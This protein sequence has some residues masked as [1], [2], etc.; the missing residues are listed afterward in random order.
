MANHEGWYLKANVDISSLLQANKQANSLLAT[1]RKVDAGSSSIH[2]ND[3]LARTIKSADIATASYIERLKSEGKIYEAN[4]NKASLFA[5]QIDKLKNHQSSLETQLTKVARASGKNS[6]AYN[7]QKT[8]I[9]QTATAINE[10]NAKLR[11][12]QSEMSKLKPTGFDAWVAKS[13]KVNQAADTM[14]EKIHGAWDHIKGG[15]TIA[16]AGIGAVGA[17]AVSGAKD[18]GELQQ[19]Y[20]EITNLATLG[21]EKQKA[22]LK[23]VAKM[24]SQGRDMSIQYGKS[25][26][27]IAYGYEDLVKRGYTTKQA[28]GAMRTELQASVASGDKFSDVTTVSSQVL[29]SFGMRADHTKE[30]L[31]NTKTVVN[32]LAYSADAT[33]TGFKDIG[34]GMSYVGA[35]AK[36]AHVSLAETASAMGVLSNNGLEADKA[37]T[38]LRATINSISNQVNKIGSKNSIFDKLGIK[39]SEMVNAKGQLKSL[40]SVMSTLYSHI[41]SKSHDSV[42]EQGYFKSIFG[43]TGMNAAIILAKNTGELKELTRRTAEAGSKGNYVAELAR[44]NGQT[45]QMQFARAKQAAADFKI[46]IGAK[47]L[48]VINDLG[49]DLAKFLNSSDGKKFEKNVAD[50]VKNFGQT[51]I[52]IVK[53]AEQHPITMKVI[54]GGF[55]V[56]YAGVKFARVISFLGDLKSSYDKLAETTPKI[57]KL[58]DYTKELSKPTSFKNMSKAGKLTVAA[59]VAF[60]A[61]Q[62]G[63][64]FQQ[65]A[66]A[67]NAE[68]RINNVGKGIGGIIGGAI[69][70]SLGGFAGAQIGMS[71]GEAMGPS[72]AK[73]FAENFSGHVTKY[74]VYGKKGSSSNGKL[75]NQAVKYI[76]DGYYDVS[77]HKRKG[78]KALYAYDANGYYD[79]RGKYHDQR[80]LAERS[81]GMSHSTDTRKFY[82]PNNAWDWVSGGANLLWNTAG[83]LNDRGFWRRSSHDIRTQSKGSWADFS[84]IGNWFN[85]QRIHPFK[86]SD[87]AGKNHDGKGGHDYWPDIKKWFGS[88]KV[89]GFKWSPKG[90]KVNS[91]ISKWFSDFFHPQVHGKAPSI[92]KMKLQGSSFLPKINGKKWSQGIVKSVKSGWS[93]FTGWSKK[94]GKDSSNKLK[95]GWNGMKSWAGKRKTDIHH[96]WNG[97]TRWAKKLGHGSASKLKGGW[98]GFKSWAG[99]RKKDVGHGWSG[100]KSWA[101]KLGQSSS[102][103]LKGGWKGFKSWASQRK[104]D[105]HHGWNGFTGWSRN[106]GKN[107]SKLLKSGW[108]GMKSWASQRFGQVKSGWSGTQKWFS[109]LGSNAVSAFKKAWS[110]IGDWAKGIWD[111]VSGGINTAVKWGK[112]TWN[113]VTGHSGKGK[114]VKSHATGGAIT[115]SHHALVGEGGPELAYKP[116]ANHARIL[117]A[118]GPELT[119]V[120]AGEH[121]L[122]A[123]DTAKVMSGG[124]GKGY[125]LKGYAAGTTGLKRTTKKVGNDYK[126]M[127]SKSSKELSSFSRKSQRT[128]RGITRKTKKQTATTRK[129]T[130]SDFRSLTRQANKQT[131]K[132]RKNSISDFTSMRK[133]VHSQM[134]KL[135]DGVIDL[136]ESTAKGFGKAM[137]KLHDYARS[138]MSDTIDQINK[139]IRGIDKVLSQFG[140]NASVIK[141]VKFAT[142]T[143][144][145]GRLTKNTLAMLNDAEIG[146]RQEAIVT[147]KNEILMPQGRNTVMPLKRGWGV[148]NGTQTQQ[149]GLT[150]FAKGSG[151]S[152][153]QLKKIASK[154]GANPAKSFADMF[155]KLLRPG[156]SDLSH[157]TT[158]L[159]QNSSTHFGVPWNNAMW[160]VINNAIG[161][162]TGKGGTREAFLKYAESTFSGVRYVMGAASKA[163]SDCS[164]MVMQA[165]R[166]FGVDIGRSTV[167]MQHSSGVQYLGKSLA[168]T[169]PGDLVIFGHGTGAAGHVGI[170]KNPK[171]G[172]MFNETPPHARVTDIASDKSMGYGYY[173]V[174]GLHN[175]SSKKG[176]G[177]KADKRL[178]SLAKRQLGPAA[179]K[180]IK[181]KLGDEG[182]LGGNI[183]GEGVKRWAGTVKKIL[184]MLHLST[185]ESM[186]NRVLRQIN[187]ESSG[188]P[189]AKQ[190]GADPDGD[191]SGPAMGLMQTKRSTFN[192][193]KRKG[194]SGGIFNGPSN[195]Y[196]GL[197]YAKH[198]YGNSLSFLG[199]G[200]GYALGGDAKAGEIAMVGEKGPEIVQ[201][202]QPTHIYPNDQSKKLHLTDKPNKSK[203]IK[204]NRGQAP[205]I[206]ININGPISSRGDAIRL[207]NI[208]KEK[209]AEILYDLM[210]KEHG[211]DLSLY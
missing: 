24:Q 173:R 40:S 2:G 178:M 144:S 180:W 29:D 98:N 207:G 22:V 96:G 78:Q 128:W 168:N 15:A 76:N 79:Q 119:R 153:S 26:K 104:R 1:L 47:L 198:R 111:K 184:G 188:N 58:G 139:G 202:K 65:A 61:V 55:L 117:G 167:D 191:G 94:L 91:G 77:T 193:Y 116:S 21:G 4:K 169:I 150:R 42:E 196:A 19:R 124:L 25:Q 100:F 172:T 59:G 205:V 112:D 51:L 108:S 209:V 210:G 190:P 146:P 120:H 95:S 54:G 137:N 149:L 48:P 14:K 28:L 123:R 18:A 62:I 170:I 141:P 129:N 73:S 105:V 72:A 151:I 90:R 49:N 36:A 127:S 174:K 93:G 160:T 69:G 195:I 134:D 199:N 186:V 189:H 181:D 74:Y 113:K 7:V 101:S 145:N 143:D 179:I 37:G 66:T 115:A 166:H 142:G 187:T 11:A 161:G 125:A 208:I 86:L 67:K 148:L 121:I 157:G 9:N 131:N 133:G 192:A 107:S 35:A 6:D 16:A 163:A 85:K 43:T 32:E 109:N 132:T 171:T 102:K 17:A 57:Q 211:A 41:E 33:S 45:A 177:I 203:T 197:N 56:G 71:L 38:G 136:G 88:F 165:L 156:K 50:V 20:K 103:K 92:S 83:H 53:F 155:T 118:N 147:D 175:A 114:S 84:G 140:G 206:N 89:D 39:K 27:E 34:I 122:N 87:F 52:S 44:K 130:I 164:G 194:D 158:G 185:S 80:S 31:K 63:S 200:H 182:S 68:A 70:A 75:T 110:G 138:A 30:M 97:F 64:A 60:D 8:R 176:K 126:S 159:A 135:H 82:H 46:E 152:H 154:N 10:L 99:K 23:S 81:W 204:H 3:S 183:G 13:R 106:L 201:F 5:S 162:A 12:T